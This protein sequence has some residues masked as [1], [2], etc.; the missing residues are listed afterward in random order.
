MSVHTALGA[1]GE[2]VVAAWLRGADIPVEPSPIADLRVAG[3]DVE[4]KTARASKYDQTGKPG[5]Q[6]CLH[7]AGRRGVQAPVVVLLA[8]RRED[9]VAFVIPRTALG[10][11]P[12]IALWGDPLTYTGQWAQYRGRWEILAEVGIV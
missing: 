1:W 8:V 9:V 4:V 2:T 3:V 5:Y 12:K 7:R 10:Q 11:R 6:F